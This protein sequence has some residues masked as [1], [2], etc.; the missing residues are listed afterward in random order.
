M[1][2]RKS[3][4]KVKSLAIVTNVESQILFLRGHKVILDRDLAQIYGVTTK[5]LNEQIK[6]NRGRFP[7]DFTFQLTQEEAENLK[8]HFATS[9]LGHGGRRKLSHVFTEHGALMAASVLNTLRAIAMSVYVVRAF[10]RMR[11]VLMAN[12]VMEKRLAEIEKTLLH[13]NV[14]LNDLY[15]KIR[16]LLLPVP[17]RPKRKMGFGVEEQEAVYGRNGHKGRR[18]K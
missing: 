10:V 6:R 12:Q 8:S 2:I 7:P 5:R 18:W 1:G 4:E 9:S 11:E 13:H 14:A 16:P 17:D 15:H 3:L